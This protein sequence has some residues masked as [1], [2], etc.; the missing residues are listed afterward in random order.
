MR[1][2]RNCF[3]LALLKT[4]DL[5]SNISGHRENCETVPSYTVTITSVKM[6]T[7]TVGEA[8]R[9]ITTAYRVERR[10]ASATTRYMASHGLSYGVQTELLTSTAAAQK[11]SASVRPRSAVE[12]MSSDEIRMRQIRELIVANEPDSE[13]EFEICSSSYDQLKSEFSKDDE[14][15]LYAM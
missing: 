2:R 6:T 13:Y 3:S 9:S 12:M 5:K 7:F 8:R 14:N 15:D 4:S 10:N 1:Q 11:E